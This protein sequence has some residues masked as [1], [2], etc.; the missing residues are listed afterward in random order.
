MSWGIVYYAFPVLNP[1]ITQAT[2]WS[3]GATTAA[4]SLGLVASALA[5][6]RVGR[7]LD[8]RGPRAVMTIGSGLGVTSLLVVATAP[9]TEPS[10]TGEPQGT[11]PPQQNRCA[12]NVPWPPDGPSP[13]R[14]RA[15][16]EDLARPPRTPAQGHTRQY[17]WCPASCSRCEKSCHSCS[18]W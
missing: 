14:K 9:N 18:N 12:L 13:A 4:F 15:R 6:I 11:S 7:I 16:P 17:G 1:Q 2:G 3:A 5:G 8:R 10:E